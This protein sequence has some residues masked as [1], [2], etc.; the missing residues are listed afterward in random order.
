MAG[1]LKRYGPAYI[2]NSVADILTTPASGIYDVIRHIHV[3]NVTT[4]PATFTRYIGGT[5][6]TS[7]GTELFKLVSVAANS[8][9]DYFTPTKMANTEYLSGLCPTGAST[10]TVTVDFEQFVV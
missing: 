4:G 6:G 5:G 1:Q 3:A 8:T 7:G 10:L 2:G 9:F